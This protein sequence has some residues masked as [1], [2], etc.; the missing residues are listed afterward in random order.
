MSTSHP[1]ASGATHPA[2][3]HLAASG[4][5]QPAASHLTP[6]ASHST[7]GGARQSVASNLTQ[8]PIDDMK[9]FYGEFG[10]HPKL[11]LNLRLQLQTTS[12]VSTNPEAR[13]VTLP[14]HHE[15]SRWKS[16]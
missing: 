16:L 15:T 4:T 3:S 10:R 9:Q 2:A 5:S 8:R 12:E 6:A 1:L 7:A 13:H 11:T 14:S